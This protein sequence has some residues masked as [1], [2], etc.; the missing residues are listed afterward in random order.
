MKLDLAGAVCRHI[1]PHVLGLATR[2]CLETPDSVLLLPDE[3]V[4]HLAT[5]C[6][7]G[8]MIKSLLNYVLVTGALVVGTIKIARDGNLVVFLQIARG[9]NSTCFFVISS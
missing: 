4:L 7:T 5:D 8:F 1:C 9:N 6:E 2:F 3:E